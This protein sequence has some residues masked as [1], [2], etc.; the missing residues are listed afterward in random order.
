MENPRFLIATDLSD[1]ASKATDYAIEFGK[2]FNASLLLLHIFEVANV[3][4]NSNKLMSA[5]FLNREIKKQI[6]GTVN[7]IESKHGLQANYM[8]KEGDL[9]VLLGEAASETHS[10]IMFIGTHGI[11]GVQHIIGSF[12][13]KVIN[14]S[15]LPILVV[16]K[17]SKPCAL[18]SIAIWIDHSQQNPIEGWIIAIAKSFQTHIHFVFSED[19]VGPG[20]NAH[21]DIINQSMQQHQLPYTVYHINEI[22]DKHTHFLNYASSIDASLLVCCRH[23]HLVNKPIEEIITNKHHIPVLCLYVDGK[24]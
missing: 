5:N 2:R 18:K 12:I 4:A 19:A 8:S 6:Q 14:G 16:Q 24:A 13:A 15:A 11:R 21:V 23:G 22:A 17:E 3:D 10:D 1:A 9:F 7:D 20:V